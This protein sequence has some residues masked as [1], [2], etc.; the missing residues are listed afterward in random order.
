MSGSEEGRYYTR[1]IAREAYDPREA[2]RGIVRDLLDPI[3]HEF[4]AA[5]EK[6][7]PDK[8]PAD[9]HWAYHFFVNALLLTLAN[10]ARIARLSGR[11]VQSLSNDETVE[12]LVDFIGHALTCGGPYPRHSDS[13]LEEPMP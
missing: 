4:L 3:A 12:R 5:L 10:P 13:V 8:P 1:L 11:H 2:E 7:L 6:A 9:V